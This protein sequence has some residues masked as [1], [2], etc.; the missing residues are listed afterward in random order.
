MMINTPCARPVLG[1]GH[2]HSAPLTTLEFTPANGASEKFAA[3]HEASADAP[4]SDVNP[5]M[6]QRLFDLK[7]CFAAVEFYLRH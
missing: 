5:S 2:R 4:R 6:C 3:R 7:R 1:D